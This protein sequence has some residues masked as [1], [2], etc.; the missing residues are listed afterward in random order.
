[1]ETRIQETQEKRSLFP[2]ITHYTRGIGS[3]HWGS[4]TSHTT[5]HVSMGVR[6]HSDGSWP[7]IALLDHDLMSNSTTCRVKVDTMLLCEGFDLLVF[8]QVCLA[9]ILYVVVQCHN[10]LFVVMDL[11]CANGHEFEGYRPAVVMRHAEPRGNGDIIATPDELP[12]WETDCKALYDLLGE[13]LGCLRRSGRLERGE[14]L[15]DGGVFELSVEGILAPWC[16]RRIPI[17]P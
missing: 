6:R 7:R 2:G 5:I 4:Q 11:G 17:G 8:L 14:D 15:G 12:F 9:L 1:M 10:N 13:G 3:D 16:R